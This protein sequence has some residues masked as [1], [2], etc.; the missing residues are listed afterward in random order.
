M[1]RR[2]AGE[3]R[4]ADEEAYVEEHESVHERRWL[5]G[6]RSEVLLAGFDAVGEA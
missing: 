5:D 4:F 1:E 6:S 2:P 3:Q